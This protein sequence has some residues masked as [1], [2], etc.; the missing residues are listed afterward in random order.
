MI[1][2]HSVNLLK[3][4]VFANDCCQPAGIRAISESSFE[5]AAAVTML[6][7]DTTFIMH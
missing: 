3:K 7:Q 4:L 2:L 6:G 1:A 5:A